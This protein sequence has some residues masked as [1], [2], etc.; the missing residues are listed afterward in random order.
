MVKRILALSLLITVVVMANVNCQTRGET[1][2]LAPTREQAMTDEC[3]TSAELSE[4]N[5]DVGTDHD[6]MYDV[7]N[8]P[9]YGKHCNGDNCYS[10]G[11]SCVGKRCYVNDSTQGWCVGDDCWVNGSGCCAGASCHVNGPGY[12]QGA[13][14]NVTG[15]MLPIRCCGDAF[16]AAVHISIRNTN[17]DSSVMNTTK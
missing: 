10:L 3:T 1:A 4:I 11:G 5:D 6:P 13:G 12:C 15:T 2:N 16:V 9:D 14:C 7:S 17:A 8:N